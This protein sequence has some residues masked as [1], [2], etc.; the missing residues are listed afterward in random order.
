MRLLTAIFEFLFGC[1][2]HNLTRVFTI[3]ARTYKVCMDCGAEFEYSLRTMSIRG[4]EPAWQRS[5]FVHGSG[6]HTWMQPTPSKLAIAIAITLLTVCAL[7]TVVH[8]QAAIVQQKTATAEIPFAFFT[9]DTKCP[10]GSYSV[11][12]I[13]PAHLFIRNKKEHVAAEIFTISDPGFPVDTKEAKLVFVKR[14]GRNYFVGIVARYQF[15]RVSG[16]YG[17]TEKEG[18]VRT[19]I[20]LTYAEE[21]AKNTVGQAQPDTSAERP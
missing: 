12:V 10:A 21:R 16:L 6:G 7:P 8:G 1:H 5:A 2:H 14:E 11:E 20:K 4:A 15:E 9:L 3:R 13:G 17:I 19:E 18:D